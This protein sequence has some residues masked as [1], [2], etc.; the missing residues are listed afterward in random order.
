MTDYMF[1][2][3]RPLFLRGLSLFHGWL[4]FLLRFLVI[5]LGY[6]RRAL[7]AW[8]GLAWAAILVSYLFLP[9]PGAKLANPLAPVNIDYV[10]G[11]SDTAA[12]TWMPHWAWLVLLLVAMPAVIFIPTHWL[13]G[14]IS[15][16]T[17]ASRNEHEP[18]LP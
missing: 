4:P 11:F 13:L 2:A 18:R 6:D 17:A 1:D 16:N 5:R 8:T 9:A 14:K 7:F 15:R 12:Q 3:H 10:Y